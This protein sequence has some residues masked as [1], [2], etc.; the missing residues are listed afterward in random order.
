M[1]EDRKMK[2]RKTAGY[3][4]LGK[5]LGEK[6]EIRSLVPYLK[7]PKKYYQLVSFDTCQKCKFF[8]GLE[9]NEVLCGY[10]RQKKEPLAK[11]VLNDLSGS[12]WLFFTKSVLRTSFPLELGHDLRKEHGASKP[13]R[14]MKLIVEF[15]TK[16]GEIVLDPF[17]GVGGT[18]LGASLCARD[19]IGI[20]VN[21]KW[22][23]I[24]EKVCSREGIKKQ[25]MIYGDCLEKLPKFI[26]QRKKFSAIITDPPYSPA[27]KKTLCDGKYGWARRKTD[28]ESFSDNPQD[29]RN[30]EGFAEYY[31]RMETVGGLMYNVLESNRY[32]VVMIRDSYQNSRYIPASFKV[33]E[34]M[35]NVGFTFKGIKI[36]HQTGAPV[37]PYGYPWS[38][39][40]NIVHHNILIFRKQKK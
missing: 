34:R 17:A 26:E 18:L 23:D 3:L 32:L 35:Q 37:R 8:M 31:D 15:F 13:P 5:N 12:E 33:A 27:L 9:N 16:P 25:Q 7:C 14:L 20:E 11:N 4:N 19:A 39:V 10:E 2:L 22:I 30:S 1:I 21:K 28:L 36:W 6:N 29:F 38:Y 24:Y 40:P